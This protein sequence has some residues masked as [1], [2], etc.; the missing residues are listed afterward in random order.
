MQF[1]EEFGEWTSK[2]A[3]DIR[4]QKLFL[5]NNEYRITTKPGKLYITFF[6]EPRAAFE[7]PAFRNKILRAYRL[8]DKAEVPLKTENGKTTFTLERPILDPTATVVVIEFEGTR[9]EK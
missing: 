3:K 5:A 6:V 8:A 9:I 2:D 4:G 1:G 7:M